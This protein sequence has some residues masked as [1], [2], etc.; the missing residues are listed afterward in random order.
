ML[1]DRLGGPQDSDEAVEHSDKGTPPEILCEPLPV[2]A[3]CT[4]AFASA[5]A[6]SSGVALAA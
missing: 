2:G 1:R 3:R 4:C 6:P 5:A